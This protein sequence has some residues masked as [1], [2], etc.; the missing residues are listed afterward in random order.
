MAD[1]T[2][3][4]AQFN[5]PSVGE[6]DMIGLIVK[7]YP[8]YGNPFLLGNP[9]LLLLG[10][11]RDGLFMAFQ[12][13]F[14]LRKARKGLFFHVLVACDTFQTLLLM[15]LMVKLDGLLHPPPHD[16]SKKEDNYHDE[17]DDSRQEKPTPFSLDYGR[18]INL[19]SEWHP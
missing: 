9:N 19:F 7:A 14:Y 17:M 8:F 1:P 16:R 12:T 2:I 18:N 11:I 4:P 6:E 5:V 3:D 13:Y 10:A 15:R